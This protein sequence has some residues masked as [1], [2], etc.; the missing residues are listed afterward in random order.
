MDMRPKFTLEPG[1]G[2]GC[3]IADARVRNN[4]GLCGMQ[5]CGGKLG[6]DENMLGMFFIRLCDSCYEDYK[7]FVEEMKRDLTHD[8]EDEA[9]EAR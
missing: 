7:K 1:D 6:K 3:S 9:G 5:S 4:N 2:T 8:E